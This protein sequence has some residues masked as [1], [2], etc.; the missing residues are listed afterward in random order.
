MRY[1]IFKS[2]APAMPRPS[3]GTEIVTLLLSRVSKEMKTALVPMAM[4]ALAARMTEVRA[5]YCDNKFYEMCGQMGHLVGSSG[6]GKGQLTHL[7][8]AIMRPARQHDELEYKKLTEWQRQTKTKGANK[9]KPERPETPFWF[10]PADLTN[11][12]FLQNAMALE[13]DGCR[14]QYLNLPEVEMANHMF[15]SHRKVSQM[16]RNIYDCQRAGALRATADGVSGNP[17]LRVNITFSSTP[18][19]ARAF[20]DKDLTNGFFGRIPFAYVARGERVGRIPR[21]GT[22]SEAFLTQLEERLARLDRCHGDFVVHS[23]NRVADHLA[24]QMAELADMADD[25]TLFEL[26]H[27]SIFAA[28]KKGVVLWA[29]NGQ[30]WTKSIGDFVEWFCYYDMWSKVQV[31]GDLFHRGTS[32]SGGRGAQKYGPKNMLDSLGDSFTKEQLVAL[33][34][35]MD[36]S[37]DGVGNML[38]TWKFRGFV[39]Y[40][41]LTG[42]Y[43]KTPKYLSPADSPATLPVSDEPWQKTPSGESAAS[44]QTAR[45]AKTAAAGQTATSGKASAGKK[46]FT[47]KASPAKTAAEGQTATSGKSSSGKKASSGK[48]PSGK[49]SASGKVSQENASS[50]KTSPAKTAAAGQSAP[51]GES[52]SEQ[53]STAAGELNFTED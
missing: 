5:M 35:E 50:G 40:D 1:D 4:P 13:N 17:V 51:A 2:T 20:Y 24:E 39:T 31:F 23:L 33:R 32:A 30:Q 12:A 49:T 8:E 3:R 44:G 46:T 22:Y 45:P 36:M 18:D 26:S 28:W 29:L 6:I 16:V 7:I 48:V 21:Q 10:P 37:A 25:D 52:S 53:Q 11:P 27:R 38:K 47:G 9:E 41:A 19:A 15:G 42:L 14:T 43:T 34:L